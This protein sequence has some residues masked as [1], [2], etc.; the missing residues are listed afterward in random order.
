MFYDKYAIWIIQI[1]HR[2]VRIM[3]DLFVGISMNLQSTSRES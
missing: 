3:T 2:K 1:A